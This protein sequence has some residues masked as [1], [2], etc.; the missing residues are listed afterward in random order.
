M[1]AANVLF[2]VKGGNHPGFLHQ[3]L[4]GIKQLGAMAHGARLS[5]EPAKQIL[6]DAIH[7]P[8]VATRQHRQVAF[9]LL[10]QLQQ[11]VLRQNFRMGAGLAERRRAF[12]R[13]GTVRVQTT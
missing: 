4:N 12:H 3:R 7:I 13:T 8:L 10:Q 5:V 11:P 9:P 2:A 1:D 6:P